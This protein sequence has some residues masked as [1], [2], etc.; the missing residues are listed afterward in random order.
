M[1]RFSVWLVYASLN[2]TMPV[3][4]TLTRHAVEQGKI[5]QVIDTA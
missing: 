1:K 2:E 3:V 4:A 5:S